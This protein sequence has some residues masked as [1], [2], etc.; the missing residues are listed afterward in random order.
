MLDA[1]LRRRDPVV[2][3]LAN[4]SAGAYLIPLTCA[5]VRVGE[6]GRWHRISADDID[7]IVLQNLARVDIVV[8][9]EHLDVQFLPQLRWHAPWASLNRTAHRNGVP[10][11]RDEQV[12]S[13]GTRAALE[14]F[15]PLRRDSMLHSFA[16]RVARA[17]AA[18]AASCTAWVTKRGLGDATSSCAQPTHRCKLAQSACPSPCSIKVNP[19]EKALLERKVSHV[20]HCTYAD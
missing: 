13:R 8:D 16:A 9:M 20:P 4:Q 1:L 7:A 11:G 5:A 17:R 15:P 2:H 3:S 6:V 14:D 12:L 10:G 18:H 19:T